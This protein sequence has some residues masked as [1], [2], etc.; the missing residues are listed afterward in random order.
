MA[1]TLQH[2]PD[3]PLHLLQDLFSGLPICQSAAAARRDV[4]HAVG[5]YDPTLRVAEDYDLWL[6]LAP[7][8]RFAC[9][10]A[11]T[12]TYRLHD[13][14][15]S[16]RSRD[17]TLGAWQVRLRAWHRLRATGAT[18]D[19]ARAAESLARILARDLR[20]TWYWKDAE[21]FDRLLALAPEVPGAVEA[22]RPWRLRRRWLWTASRWAQGL[23]GGLPEPLRTALRRARA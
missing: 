8:V 5:G 4:L 6:R 18:S 13:A 20:D 3:E 12:V 22:A 1:H 15:T 21:L 16:R 14:Q 23:A 2:P 7:I 10:R 11:V 17:L 9:S 19:V